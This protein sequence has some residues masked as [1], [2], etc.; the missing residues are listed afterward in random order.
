MINAH[1]PHAFFFL[2]FLQDFTSVLGQSVRTDA[3]GDMTQVGRFS[4]PMQ[5][6]LAYPAFAP[7]YP[8]ALVLTGKNLC[9]AKGGRV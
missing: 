4:L 3:V 9:S 1:T 6:L 5:G 7:L 2:T 8:K